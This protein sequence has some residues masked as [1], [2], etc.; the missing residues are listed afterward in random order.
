MNF[1]EAWNYLEK[2]SIY[3]GHF[4]ECLYIEV[5]KVNPKTKR[6]ENDENLNT[7]IEVWLESGPYFKEYSTHDI[8]LDCGGNSFES[9]ICEL[10]KLVKEKY[11]DD[12]EYSEK[13][14]NEK[15]K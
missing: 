10:A 14:V 8:D 11:T 5:V 7:S 15:Y 6:I 12:E 9:S 2:H 1:Y 13:L 4:Q 3:K